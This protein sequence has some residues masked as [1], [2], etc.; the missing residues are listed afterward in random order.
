LGYS[1]NTRLINLIY[2]VIVRELP[3][4]ILLEEGVL[5]RVLERIENNGVLKVLESISPLLF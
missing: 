5:E 1:L 3:V 2:I 4:S